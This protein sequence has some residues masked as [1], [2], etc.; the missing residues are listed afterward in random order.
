[1][2]IIAVYR[3]DLNKDREWKVMIG[4]ADFKAFKEHIRIEKSRRRVF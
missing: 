4:E 3:H 1:M 2:L